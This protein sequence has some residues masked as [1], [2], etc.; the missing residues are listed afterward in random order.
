MAKY[1]IPVFL[2]MLHFSSCVTTNYITIDV[3][4]P[5]V[6]SFEPEIKNIV[7][8]NNSASQADEEIQANGE[9]KSDLSVIST[10]SAK[11]L[12][13]SSLQQFMNEEKYFDKVDIY[14][15]A[16]NSGERN[17]VKPLSARNVQTICHERKADAL[18][19]LD[20]FLVTAELE[21][22]STEYFSVYNVLKA[23]I[24]TMMRV[25]NIDGSQLSPPIAHVDS[26]FMEGFNDWS[27]LSNSIPEINKL[28]N[29]ISVKAAD[30]I[31]SVF[32]PSWKTQDRWFYSDNSKEQKNALTFVKNGKWQ[33]AANIWGELFEKETNRNKKIRLASNIAL[34]NESLDDVDN[35][36]SWIDI[37]F[38]LLPDSSKSDLTAEIIRYKEILTRRAN[39]NPKLYQQLGIEPPIEE[40]IVE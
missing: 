24:G 2:L 19:A 30:D 9:K 17:D 20:L 33:E 37:A 21:S 38:D 10:D 4:E 35:A 40:D 26:L 39:N 36:V 28:V 32:I 8:V 27:K 34:A 14:P 25:Y 6:V 23:K 16:T 7:I 1:I 22:V 12:F 5:A 31:T 3:R 11:I 15:Y 29:D 18:I 13:T